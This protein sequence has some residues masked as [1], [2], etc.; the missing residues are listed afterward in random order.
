M[1]QGNQAAGGGDK[2]LQCCSRKERRTKVSSYF[3]ALPFSK[4]IEGIEHC[5]KAICNNQCFQKH[6]QKTFLQDE[7]KCV[8]S[9]EMGLG[10]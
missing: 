6:A 10:V 5:S 9:L 2:N 8:Y 3:Q 7:D 4:A 1:F